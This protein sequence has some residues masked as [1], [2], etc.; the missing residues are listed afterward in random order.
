MTAPDFSHFQVPT[1]TAEEVARRYAS[2]ES[3]LDA[4]T[5]LAAITVEE[6][7]AVPHVLPRLADRWNA[8]SPFGLAWLVARLRPPGGCPW[9]REQTHLTMPSF[10]LEQ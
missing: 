10:L 5:T 4:A 6:L 1:P 7:A 2:L 9:D 8:A 3:E